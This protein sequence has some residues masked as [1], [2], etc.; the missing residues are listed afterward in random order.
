MNEQNKEKLGAAA[1]DYIDRKKMQKAALVK[2]GAMLVLSTIILIFSTISW[3]TRNNETN[4]NGMKVTISGPTYQISVLTNG[5]DGVYKSYQD[6][7][8]DSSA[9]V[10]QMKGT[11]VNSLDQNFGNYNPI[12]EGTEDDGI[13]PG[14][15]GY[16]SFIVTPKVDSVNL[17][18]T[19]DLLGYDEDKSKTPPLVHLDDTNDA[20]V[21]NYLNGHILLFESY[22][23]TTH[24]YSGLIKN[25]TDLSRVLSNKTFT[26]KDTPT[27]I[28]IYWVWAENLSDLLNTETVT[29]TVHDDETNTDETEEVDRSTFCDDEDFLDY[30]EDNPHYFMRGVTASDN[31]TISDINAN[32]EYYG[33]RYNLADNVIGSRV[34]FLLLTMTVSSS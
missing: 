16:I 27:T 31:V 10:W 19:F 30:I 23:P 5:S 33:G 22:N 11:D 3:F 25:S 12:P 13:Y 7:V 4:T 29:I 34:R 1:S 17:N 18:F 32:Y 14:C 15:S 2:I 28:N 21:I 24:K 6:L 20:D 8:G 26:G 9:M